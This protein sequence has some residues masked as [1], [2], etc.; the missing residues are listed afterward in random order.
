MGDY[1]GR[2]NSVEISKPAV[3]SEISYAEREPRKI[4]QD[5]SPDDNKIPKGKCR[6]EDLVDIISNNHSNP[7][8]WNVGTISEHLNLR[9]TEVELFLSQFEP[10][11]DHASF[12]LTTESDHTSDIFSV[13]HESFQDKT[14]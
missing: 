1:L 2:L 3:L 10:I 5:N 7:K 14:S 12:V 9:P 8:E 11:N 13:R 6:P 4:K